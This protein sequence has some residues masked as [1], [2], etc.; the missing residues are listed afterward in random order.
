MKVLV[1]TPMYGGMATGAYTQSV[2]QLPV[3]AK[4]SG[5]EVSFGFIYNNSLVPHARNQL[6][7]LCLKHDFTHLFFIDA[8]IEFRPPDFMSMLAAD[9]D[10]IAGIYPKK[11][12]M[13]DLVRDA[14][15][16]GVPAEELPKHAGQLVV[17]FLG[18]HEDCVVSL[19][20]PF[21]VKA[22]GTGFMCIKREVLERME[23]LNTFL[24]EEEMLKEY[25]P[26][27]NEP[28]TQ[29]QMSEDIAFCYLCRQNG[30]KI[31]IAP[32]VQLRHMGSYIYDGMPI[33]VSSHEYAAKIKFSGAN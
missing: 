24:H 8:D 16:R 4:E 21:E 31:H 25:F 5:V 15:L 13:W 20:E 30:I 18:A 28:G 32:W 19:H 7:N 1:A 23:G 6:A 12:I 33:M 26:L 11:R 14:V 10:V 27:M 22:A 29:V 9:K 2:T 3:L 17:N